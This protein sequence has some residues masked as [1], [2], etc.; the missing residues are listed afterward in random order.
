[1]RKRLMGTLTT[2]SKHQA[3]LVLRWARSID[4]SH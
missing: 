4:D 1:M 2:W 3:A